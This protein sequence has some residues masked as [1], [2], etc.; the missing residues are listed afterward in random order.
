ML[1]HWSRVCSLTGIDGCYHLL[2]VHFPPVKGFERGNWDRPFAGRK[3]G[4]NVLSAPFPD[5]RT[6]GL[7]P[8]MLSLQAAWFT[9]FFF[10]ELAAG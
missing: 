9:A 8:E 2:S 3:N 10:E 7:F 5:P 1:M 6:V 4:Q